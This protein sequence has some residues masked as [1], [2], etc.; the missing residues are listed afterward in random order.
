MRCG[1][2]IKF[3]RLRDNKS[4][5]VLAKQAGISKSTLSNIENNIT[6]CKKP[7]LSKICDVLNVSYEVLLDDI[8]FDNYVF[9]LYLN[10]LVTSSYVSKRLKVDSSI[11]KETLMSLLVAV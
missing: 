6:V 5:S 7:T 9:N 11:V 4:L 3:L 10:D 1:D 2:K 8:I